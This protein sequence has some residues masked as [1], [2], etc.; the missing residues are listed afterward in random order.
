MDIKQLWESQ[1]NQMDDFREQLKSPKEFY[2]TEFNNPMM[3]KLHKQ[4]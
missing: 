1:V 4:I 2:P 3:K